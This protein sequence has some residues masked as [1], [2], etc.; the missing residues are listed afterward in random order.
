[1]NIL[2]IFTWYWNLFR[3]DDN[4][5]QI[6]AWATT[7]T[8]LTFLLTFI[9]K[10]L[11][12]YFINVIKVT[13][14]SSF[15][16]FSELKIKY[17]SVDLKRNIKIIVVD[18][19]DI[20]PVNGFNEFGYKIDR[21]EK[22]DERKLK[23]LKDGEFDIIILD[24]IGIAK[25]ISE[26]DGLGVLKD[27]KANNPSQ[28]IVA[29]SGQSF[30]IMKNSFWDLADEKLGKP[31]PFIGTQEI[32]DNLIE[33]TFT[34]QYHQ[35]KIEKILADSNLLHESK[36]IQDLFMRFKKT[37]SEP[38]WQDQLHDI[39]LRNGEKIKIASI[40]SK[41]FRLTTIA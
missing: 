8:T 20:F 32:I 1:M 24:I 40:L 5:V 6:A 34:V 26:N 41:L 37:N 15:Q 3:D 10:P 38:V 18:D 17:T 2:N 12:N 23:R 30:D 35:N 7:I 31:T 9:I 39:S 19:D 14:T 22:L 13:P 29:Y 25:D 27:I 36:R 11:R 33:R 21:W 4:K 16:T 28:V